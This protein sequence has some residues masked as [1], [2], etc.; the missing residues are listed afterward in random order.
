M[1]LPHLFPQQPNNQE[2]CL[3]LK[4]VSMSRALLILIASSCF[5]EANTLYLTTGHI[6]G[7]VSSDGASVEHTL[8]T[9]DMA[10]HRCVHSSDYPACG[11]P[12]SITGGMQLF[13]RPQGIFL[14]LDLLQELG[15]CGSGLM[16]VQSQ[17]S[18]ALC[19]HLK[20]D[21]YTLVSWAFLKFL[22]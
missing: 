8:C 2:A 18:F 4:S 6:A 15:L 7:R 10:L 16:E 17:A 21:N 12:S 19:L 14:C 11:E 5:F 20:G 3:E 22:I 1:A 13:I 9:S